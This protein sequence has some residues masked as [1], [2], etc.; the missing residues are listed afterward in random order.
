MKHLEICREYFNTFGKPMI[1][2]KFPQIKDRFA[3]GLVGEGSGCFGFDDEISRDHD[4]AP[5]FCIWLKDKD[6]AEFGHQLS[7]SYNNLPSEFMGIKK[8]SI[9]A[10]ERLGVMKISD[11]YMSF[12][13]CP[14]IPSSNM[15]WFL[16]SESNL[17]S[18][19]NGEVFEDR[20]GEF[21]RIR[22]GF[23]NFYPEDVLLKKLAA[24]C[25]VMSQSGQYNFERCI[26]R[27][28]KVSAE[29]SLAR[30]TEATISITHLL[31]RKP[32]PFY[33]WSFRNLSLFDTQTASLI[34]NL[35][36]NDG[37]EAVTHHIEAL[38]QRITSLL[39]EQGYVTPNGS[40]LQ[41]YI[42]QLMNSIEDPDI[43]TMHPMA[44]CL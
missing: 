20:S 15:D 25:A 34:L 4:F 28:D 5:G 33:K 38:C 6:F 1:E 16:I 29:L 10:P 37:F 31:Y 13:G 11:F 19:T 18:V 21:N 12:T 7:A 30:F 39:C 14:D 42:P 43:R 27:G 44:D 36:Q 22:K 17:A 3:A 9:I 2:S 35:W 40:F 8:S 24:R 32:A 26:R 41:D 23:Q